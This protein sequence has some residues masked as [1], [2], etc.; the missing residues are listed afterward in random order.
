MDATAATQAE[1]T[2]ALPRFLLVFRSRSYLRRFLCFLSLETGVE[3]SA[4]LDIFWSLHLF[5]LLIVLGALE[6]LHEDYRLLFRGL[7]IAY[8]FA[9]AA[10]LVGLERVRP[11][12][13]LIYYYTKMV[14]LC[15]CV[16]RDAILFASGYCT[17]LSLLNY[18]EG[19]CFT[20]P[21]VAYIV[22]ELF[23]VVYQ[24]HVL[25]SYINLLSL[26]IVTLRPGSH[27]AAAGPRELPS[28]TH[29]Q[30]QQQQFQRSNVVMVTNDD[31]DFTAQP[32][33]QKDI[34]VI[35]R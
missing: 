18:I 26:R 25:F 31:T 2:P 20:G 12:L 11:G 9:P 16:V 22:A 1:L 30:Q 10:A 35:K 24:L 17:D 4:T 23:V 3:A 13:F 27:L 5:V 7:Q 34:A 33:D 14:Q 21:D 29:K 28:P 32:I 6:Q 15:S 8:A 19:D